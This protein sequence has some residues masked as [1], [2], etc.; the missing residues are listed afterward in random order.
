[1]TTQVQAHYDTAYFAWQ[2]PGGQASAI[3]D[4]WK[5]KPFLASDDVVLDFGCGGGYLLSAL[6]CRSRYGVELNPAA[7]QEAGR[8]FRVLADV[9]ELPCDLLFDVIIS[10]HALEHVDHPLEVLRKLRRQLKPGGQAVVVVPSDD[11]R[12]Q[13]KYCAHD[14]N[15]HLYTWTPLSLGNLFTRAG[16]RV[17]HV[18]LLRHRWL[19]KAPTLHRLMP[20]WCFHL[21]CRLWGMATRTRQI[22][23]VARN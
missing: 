9:D 19:P 10:H 13:R 15:Q 4:A 18:Q 11:W 21:L 17:Q 3:L 5:F 20:A 7:R 22:R 16:F 14:V 2:Q 1:M 6:P 12:K 8:R 23:I